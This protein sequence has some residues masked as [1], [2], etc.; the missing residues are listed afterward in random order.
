MKPDRSKNSPA[1]YGDEAEPTAGKAEMPVVFVVILAVLIFAGGMF[2]SSTSGGFNST[3]YGQYTSTNELAALAPQD[4]G[5]K[6]F[7]QGREVYGRTCVPCHQPAGAGVAGQFPPLA[8]SEWVTAPKADRIVRIVLDG[9]QGPIS[10]KGTDW[11]NVMVR[12]KEVLSDEEVAAVLTYVRNEWGNKADP[13]KPEEVKAIRATE[14][15]RN[16]AWTAAELLKIA[17][18]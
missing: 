17:D 16:E 9:L 13:V 3:V 4:E 1:R 2:L 8:G 14:K 11:N 18:Q 15:D 12:W 6:Q 10:V 5:N 7:A